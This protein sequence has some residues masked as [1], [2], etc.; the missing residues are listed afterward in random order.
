MKARCL[1]LGTIFALFLI[2]TPCAA[3]EAESDELTASVSAMARVRRAFSPRFSPDGRRIAFI[4]DLSGV[5]QV[6][7]VPAESGW[8]QLVTSLDDP[9]GAV[10]WSPDGQWLAISVLPGGGL[11][12]QIYLVR[13]DG[14]GLR[15][16]T[17][18]GKENNWLG[19]WTRDGQR[20]TMSSNRRNAASMDCYL[21]D[22]ATG[23][24]ELISENP[25]VGVFVDVTGD[26]RHALL[27]R[28]RSRGDNNL[29]LVDLATR[30]EVLLTPHEPP[31]QFDGRFARDR[32]SVYLV[33]NADRDLFGFGRIRL[34]AD[35]KPGPIEVLAER[36][37]AEL[38]GF[39]LD[40]QG[41]IAALVWNV[42]GR[43]ELSIFDL[44]TRKTIDSPKL[45]A[46]LAGGLTFA[47]DGNLLA[48]VA[49]GPATPLDIWIYDL[50]KKRFHQVTFSPHP[51]V[52]LSKLV[53]PELV[54][55]SAHDR[56]RLTGWLYRPRGQSG[57]GPAVISF[58]GGPEA[59][60]VPVFR[61]DYQALL[62]QGIAV[63]APN[64]RGSAGFGKKFVNL[65][66]GALRANAVRDIK[67]CVDYLV[68]SGIADPRR[69]G[70]TGGSYGGYMTMAGLTEYPELFA[71]GVNL[72]GIVNFATFFEQTEPWM[73]AISRVEYGDPETEAEMLRN[74]SPIHKLDRIKAP[75]MV[76]HGA[77]DTNVP[78]VEA[79][80]I[81]EALEK[82]NVPVEYLLF[83]DEGHGWRRVPN[84]IKSTVALVHF[85]AKHLKGE[86]QPAVRKE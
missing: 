23:K 37:D 60:E 81:V 54:S 42:A 28:V 71:A 50:R 66:N 27:L 17:D 47:R 30:K 4:S 1:S 73:A 11:N 65:D 19:K 15:R 84:R 80:Q 63:F 72:F 35:G 57:P 18:G 25:G 82:R 21:I 2:W 64:V 77:N 31:A 16:L 9:V 7:V 45:P 85:F 43:N 26:R 34:S 24:L 41:R 22:P 74:L 59:Q 52:D 10:E 83:P 53:R 56:L 55:F 32:R 29:Y 48:M 69:I 51:G 61:S 20:I 40:D 39:E 5:P 8:P 13:P 76:Q 58:H 62:S 70:I 36:A 75:T 38:S 3:E 12:S 49:S 44:A 79:E 67:S 68:Q 33:S 14:S 46:E 86:G 6:W 78:V